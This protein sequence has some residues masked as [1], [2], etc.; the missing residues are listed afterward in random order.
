MRFFNSIL[1]NILLL[2]QLMVHRHMELQVR[3]MLTGILSLEDHYRIKTKAL[4][5]EEEAEHQHNVYIPYLFDCGYLY[6]CV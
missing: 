6:V 1:N 2:F 4:E 3:Q 5:G